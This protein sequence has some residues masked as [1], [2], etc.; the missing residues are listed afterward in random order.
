MLIAIN[1][2]SQEVVV[3]LVV[4]TKN[5]RNVTIKLSRGNALLGGIHGNSD[6]DIER[7]LDNVGLRLNESE[8]NG[9]DVVHCRTIDILQSQCLRQT[10][11]LDVWVGQLGIT[12]AKSVDEGTHGALRENTSVRIR[13][14]GRLLPRKL[15]Q[16]LSCPDL[17]AQRT[18]G[19]THNSQFGEGFRKQTLVHLVLHPIQGGLSIGHTL[20]SD[21]HTS[22]VRVALNGITTMHVARTVANKNN[23]V[24]SVLVVGVGTVKD[25]DKALRRNI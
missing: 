3:F 13:D 11:V 17:G 24:I 12:E 1:Q 6:G 21:G 14:N 5:I 4:S 10:L 15:G 22:R 9:F 23:S 8:G 19:T 16:N 7:L 25:T 2:I 18:S 20:L